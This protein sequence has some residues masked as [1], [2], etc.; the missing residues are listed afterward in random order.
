[1]KLLKTRLQ[2]AQIKLQKGMSTEDLQLIER[3][4]FSSPRQPRR[5]LASEFPP[6]PQS[7]SPQSRRV[8]RMLLSAM[9]PAQNSWRKKKKIR[10]QRK[11]E[12]IEDE[13]A[14]KTILMLSSSSYTSSFF[15]PRHHT[16][17]AVS[18]LPYFTVMNNTSSVESVFSSEEMMQ[19]L[20]S[21]YVY[22]HFEQ[23][24]SSDNIFDA[25]SN[26]AD[27]EEQSRQIGQALQRETYPKKHITTTFLL[28]YILCHRTIKL[29]LL[30]CSED[31]YQKIHFTLN[32]SSMKIY[33]SLSIANHFHLYLYL[34]NNY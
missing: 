34:K 7:S 23:Q 32:Q 1:M 4:F 27:Y 19:R 30:L 3:A 26:V 17:T 15:E 29:L 24:H 21:L 2:Y 20:S 25:V 10:E 12:L 13:A 8:G 16:T 31:N 5:L 18:S 6:I 22:K 9:S 28:I 11:N 14:A 33:V